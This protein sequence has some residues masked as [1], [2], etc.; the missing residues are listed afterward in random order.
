MLLNLLNMIACSQGYV[1]CE[2]AKGSLKNLARN[3]NIVS[4]LR[5]FR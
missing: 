5:N 1:N 4:F 2:V 3:F